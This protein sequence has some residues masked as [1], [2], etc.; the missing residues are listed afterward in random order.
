MTILNQ[1]HISLS[2]TLVPIIIIIKER[3]NMKNVYHYLKFSHLNKTSANFYSQKLVPAIEK[4]IM[5]WKSSLEQS[6]V[7]KTFEN[8][9]N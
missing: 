5:K 3:Y 4:V 6:D 1:R 7:K 9:D 8:L 2:G